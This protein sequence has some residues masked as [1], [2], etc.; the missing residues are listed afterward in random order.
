MISWLRISKE[1]E[2]KV[3]HFL[4]VASGWH[5]LL[6]IEDRIFTERN[7]HVC[8]FGVAWAWALSVGW[9]LFTGW[10]ID[11]DGNL[12]SIDFC[13]IWMSGKLA[14]SSYPALIYDPAAFTAAKGTF[15][16]TRECHFLHIPYPPTLLFFTYPLGLLPYLTAFSVW[17]LATI[18]LYLVA[19]YAIIPRPAAVIAALTPITVPVNVLLGHNGF[20]TAGFIGLSLVFV[21]RRAW[22]SG[23]FIG[24]LTYKP[25]FGVLFPFALLA[26]RNWRVL[27]SAAAMSVLLG[28]AAGVEFGYQGWQSFI[29]LLH[30][31]NS[32]LNPDAGEIT[33]QSV[34]GLLHWAGAS[35]WLSWTVHLAVA[36][37]VAIAV[38][39]AWAKPIPQSLKAAILCVGAVTVT[40]Y[41][42]QYDLCI[43]SIA[44][45][46]LVKDGLSHGFLPGERTAILIC[47]A[48][49]LFWLAEIPISPFVDAVILYLI[50][51]R[52]AAWGDDFLKACRDESV[53]CARS[54]AGSLQ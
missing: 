6:K 51:R 42:L 19:V 13:W 39:T 24:L 10:I 36:V 32:S 2:Q 31:R 1:P 43:L 3:G 46:F 4:G 44:V 34:Y 45:A 40:P 27:A 26:S 35:A 17:I 50:A 20:L 18:V 5:R 41:V 11:H 47:V 21:E 7:L 38:C 23:I 12:R 52:I 22:L 53:G 14:V 49:F 54:S 8:G 29:D 30:A 33:L 9:L 25:H 15:L 37:I 48:S 16:G 28:V